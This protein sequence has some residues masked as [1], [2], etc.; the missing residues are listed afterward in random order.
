MISFAHSLYLL[1]LPLAALPILLHLVKRRV[2]LRFQF[3]S[4][5]LLK[6]IEERRARR[7]PRWQELLLLIIRVAVAALL[8]FTL[9]GPRF[10]PRGGSPPRALVVVLDNS[11]SMTY[12]EEGE[13]RLARA[14]RYVRG[15]GNTESGDDLAAVIWTGSAAPAEWGGLRDSAAAAAVPA[16]AGGGVS[17]ALAMARELWREPRAR[18]RAREIAV[19]T[20]MQRVAFENLGPGASYL[21]ADARVTFYDVRSEATPAWNVELAGFNLAPAAAGFFNLNVDVRQ[22]GKPR[23]VSLEGA[24]GRVVGDVP[25][26]A[27]ATARIPLPAGG[28]YE[29]R[30][31]GGYPFDDRLSV[32]VPERAGVAY[33]VAPATPGVRL[34]EAALA[35]VGAEPAPGG[36]KSPPGIYVLPL[37]AWRESSRGRSFAEGGFIVVVAPDD[38]RGGRFDRDATLK[39]YAAG[40][41]RVVA[42]AAAIPNAASAGG[43]DTAGFMELETSAPWTA[44]AVAGDGSPFIA[45]R[46]MAEGEVF[47][48]CAPP[49]PRYA[50]FFTS[51]AFVGFA[52]DLKLRALARANPDFAARRTFAT[53]ESDPG[54]IG[55]DELYRLFPNAVVTRHPPQR[56][57]RASVPLRAPFAAAALLLLA[58]EAV[59]ASHQARA[60]PPPA[61]P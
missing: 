55:Y 14:A 33:A 3:P 21:P 47:L 26:A 10:T 17:D 6:T 46:R 40:P 36:L 25:A 37:S 19:F 24:D 13:T 52:L 18:G 29:F 1:L 45:T 2:R 50:N 16:A 28:R 32:F 58:V 15:L 56:P 31:R 48:I 54:V 60:K 23:P 4:I 41:A 30:C 44:A 49:G 51:A 53:A 38:E 9:A 12:A 39:P 35:S 57:G 7:R 42:D 5:Q 8:V 59:L 34:W 43:F 20:D 22:Y 61:R 27:R 11:P